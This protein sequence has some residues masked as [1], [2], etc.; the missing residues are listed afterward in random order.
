MENPRKLKS[1]QAIFFDYDGVLIDSSNIKTNGFQTLFNNYDDGVVDKVVNY[2]QQHGGISRVDKIRDIHQH[3]LGTPLTDD[4][5]FHWAEEY[6]KLVME[7]VIKVNWI[8]GAEEFL[9]SVHGT[10]PVFVI[11]G[12]PEEEL[13]EIIKKRKT[14]DYF[15]EILGSP[16]RKPAHIRNL[17]SA[18]NLTPE[19][20]VFVGDA[21]TDFDAAAE[22]HLRF[23][24][25]QGDI[26][27]PPG[28][29]VLPD[30]LTLQ[31]KIT[32]LFPR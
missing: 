13:R 14:P 17:L 32:N 16:V 1:L 9:D 22:T 31:E 6:S 19:R 28:T 4:E 27:F 7:K 15:Q 24:G 20:C 12:T 29:T 3:I 10:M 11:S 26:D 21:L 30:C 8:A 25:I 23:I 5:L 18:Y 2:H